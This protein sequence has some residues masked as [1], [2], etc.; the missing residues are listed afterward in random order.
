[1]RR[2]ASLG[3]IGGTMA[4]KKNESK[5]LAD[6]KDMLHLYSAV[7]VAARHITDKEFVAATAKLEGVLKEDPQ[8]PQARFLLAMCYE[9]TDRSAEAKAILDGVLKDDPENL[10]G[11]IAM[12][13]LL[14]KEGRTEEMVAVC[15]RA[16]A[17][18][19]R[20]AQAYALLADAY[21]GA[22]DYG[23]ALPYL[24]KAVE[25]QAKLT[26]NRINL[27]ACLIGLRRFDEA[28]GALK[29][30]LSTHPKCPLAHF[31]LGLLY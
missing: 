20:N 4:T 15:K 6:P 9:K 31:N 5:V 28:E 16:L 10:R 7:G 26:R 27:A 29:G 25:I 12:A 13:G 21:M 8:N 2:L 30:I 14:A 17:K 18:D 23:A 24:Q 22:N 11:L 3:Y 19:D 1:M